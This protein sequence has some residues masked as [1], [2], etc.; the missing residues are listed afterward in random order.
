MRQERLILPEVT[1]QQT[2][3]YVDENVIYC[4][5]VCTTDG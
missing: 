1:R 3:V 4:K 5:V 2:L